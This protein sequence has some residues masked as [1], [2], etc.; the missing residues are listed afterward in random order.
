M[1]AYI[2]PVSD[3]ATDEELAKI[4]GMFAN[5]NDAMRA[6]DR[7]AASEAARGGLR[8]MS[9]IVPRMLAR[10]MAQDL[11][12]D[13]LTKHNEI[14][15]ECLGQAVAMGHMGAVCTSEGMLAGSGRPIFVAIGVGDAAAELHRVL[16]AGFK[17]GTSILPNH[18]APPTDGPAI[19]G[20]ST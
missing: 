13:Q 1:S 20:P 15:G 14:V 4:A 8:L 16:S 5:V 19:E 2:P 7:I 11:R 9:T 6:G 3:Q 17:G 12:I 18:H 10:L